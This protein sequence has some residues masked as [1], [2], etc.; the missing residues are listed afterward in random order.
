MCC[1]QMEELAN[2]VALLDT[3]KGV[4]A[5]IH[6]FANL[7]SGGL[8]PRITGDSAEGKAELDN[9]ILPEQRHPVVVTTSKLLNTGVDAQT[10]KLIVLDQRIESMTTFKQIIG[11]G[12]R[13]NEDFG[14][15]LNNRFE[16]DPD[17]QKIAAVSKVHV[18]PLQE[19]Q[20]TAPYDI[21]ISGLPFN[22]FPSALV[23]ELALG[24]DLDAILI[25]HFD[26]LERQSRPA[27]QRQENEREGE[28]KGEEAHRRIDAFLPGALNASPAAD[29]M[30]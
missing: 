7:L 16:H 29:F 14:K 9:F 2:S 27:S 28:D 15:V 1:K 20:T 12:T 10:C 13:I 4:F 24:R 5:T 17:Y 30:A 6:E 21:V 23:E 8:G 11:R 22:N 18:C 3:H 26:C 19:F 25:E